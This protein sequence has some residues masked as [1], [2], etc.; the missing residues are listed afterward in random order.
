MNI[1]TTIL[2]LLHDPFQGESIVISLLDPFFVYFVT[3]EGA[4]NFSHIQILAEQKK[5][6]LST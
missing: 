6:G 2:E 5:A 1:A 4:G 3:G